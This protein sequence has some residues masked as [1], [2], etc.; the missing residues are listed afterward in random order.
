MSSRTNDHRLSAGLFR[1]PCRKRIRGEERRSIR[2][3]S[4]YR[5]AVI[6]RP[7]SFPQIPIKFINLSRGASV[8]HR[9]RAVPALPSLSLSVRVS[10]PLSSFLSP[11]SSYNSK[12]QI[13]YS[14]RCERCRALARRRLSR[15][16][17]RVTGA[18]R[19]ERRD[20]REREGPRSLL[21]GEGTKG[22][23]R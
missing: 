13:M 9:P 2:H 10:G 15:S 18:K 7:D 21:V 14:I 16:G 17:E 23:V 11:F 19:G 8:L 12:I 20:G 5:R 6:P 3:R 22:R 4:R 1:V